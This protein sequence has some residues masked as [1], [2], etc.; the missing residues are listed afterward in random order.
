MTMRFKNDEGRRRLAW[1]LYILSGI[2]LV[3]GLGMA[4]HFFQFN[5]YA[6]APDGQGFSVGFVARTE[7]QI[8]LMFGLLAVGV[9]GLIVAWR[10]S[11]GSDDE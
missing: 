9:I 8:F 5:F 7:W 6:E 10:V 4:F 2:V 3:C 11:E 1:G